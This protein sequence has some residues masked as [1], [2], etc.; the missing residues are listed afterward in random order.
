MGERGCVDVIQGRQLWKVEVKKGPQAEF[1]H[2]GYAGPK[3][4]IAMAVP[5]EGKRADNQPLNIL[6]DGKLRVEKY[7]LNT[8]AVAWK[9][10]IGNIKDDPRVLGTAMFVDDKKG[11]AYALCGQLVAAVDI[12]SGKSLWTYDHGKAMQEALKKKDKK[13]VPIINFSPQMAIHEG[14]IYLGSEDRKLYAFNGQD[15]NPLWTYNT[16]G[17]VGQPFHYEGQVLVGSSD[18]YIHAVDAKTGTLAWRVLT[19]GAVTSQPFVR[20]GMVFAATRDGQVMTVR[21]PLA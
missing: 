13:N 2:I 12:N 1:F 7:D 20:Q 6:G 16:R 17:N 4:V 10:E 15:G 3:G 8:G 11:V 19:K 18:G 14:I 9:T 21:I 5:V